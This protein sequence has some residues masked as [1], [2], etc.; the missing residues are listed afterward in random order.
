METDSIHDPSI[1]QSNPSIQSRISF[2]GS[3]LDQFPELRIL[4]QRFIF[5]HLESRAEE[6]ILE[7]VPVENAMHYESQL[8]AL[9]IN[10]V[11]SHAKAVQDSA[12]PLEFSELIQLSLHDLLG[13]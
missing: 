4:L 1:H 9:K 8:V 12:G 5:L 2:P 10:A 3:G 6:K 13:Q 11:I 7:R